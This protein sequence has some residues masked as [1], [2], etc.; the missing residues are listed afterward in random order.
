MPQMH[1]VSEGSGAKLAEERRA[2]AAKAQVEAARE[3]V[4]H[5]HAVSRCLVHHL[6]NRRC[7]GHMTALSSHFLT[8]NRLDI[9]EKDR[10]A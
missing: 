9:A 8:C 2:A 1:V 10:Y 3:D 6:Q 5:A 7:K 4:E